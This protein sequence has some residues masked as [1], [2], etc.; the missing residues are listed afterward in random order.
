M[1]VREAREEKKAAAAT[2]EASKQKK[3]KHI[4]KQNQVSLSYFC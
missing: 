1:L 2:N 4:R 3:Q